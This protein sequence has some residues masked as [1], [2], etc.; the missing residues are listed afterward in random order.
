VYGSLVIYEI[1]E[2]KI[3]K[4][5]ILTIYTYSIFYISTVLFQIID[6]LIKFDLLLLTT[7]QLVFNQLNHN[8]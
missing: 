1:K 7:D 2:Y 6:D 4:Q 8:E 5:I 3:S